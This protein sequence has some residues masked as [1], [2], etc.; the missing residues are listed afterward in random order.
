MERRLVPQR[1][2]DPPS[3]PRIQDNQILIS[4]YDET[5]SR[6]Y[7]YNHLRWR[8]SVRPRVICATESQCRPAYRTRVTFRLVLLC[9][10]TRLA[11][12]MKPEKA[13]S[14]K[15]DDIGRARLLTQP[16][17][18]RQLPVVSAFSA[19]EG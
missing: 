8:T 6:T 1:G 11:T 13:L 19:S 2:V 5:L 18:G 3:R 17:P 14:L 7:I 4:A 9:R 16:R 15:V 10:K 12:Y